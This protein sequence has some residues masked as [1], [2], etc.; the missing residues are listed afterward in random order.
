[1]IAPGRRSNTL[2]TR[3]DDDVV[4]STVLVPNVSTSMLIGW[5][6]PMAYATCTSHRLAAPE[7]TTCLA[8]QRAA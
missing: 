7:A 6:T 8:T 5:A 1:M 3:L 4:G 2:V